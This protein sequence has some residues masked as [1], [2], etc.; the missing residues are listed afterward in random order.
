MHKLRKLINNSYVMPKP[1][2]ITKNRLSVNVDKCEFML[3]AT[4]KALM[5][6]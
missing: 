6:M 2:L 1:I 3:H 5:K 4:H